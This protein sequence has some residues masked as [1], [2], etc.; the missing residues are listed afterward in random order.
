MKP[1]YEE[2]GITIYH[3]DCGDIL[4]SLPE[5]DLVLTSPPY[6]KGEK[7]NG[8]DFG[9]IKYA[10][11]KDNKPH[12]EYKEWQIGIMKNCMAVLKDNGSFLYNHKNVM[13]NNRIITPYEWIIEG[14]LL[15]SLKQEIIWNRKS[16]VQND[17][18]YYYIPITEKIF[19]FVGDKYKFN[20]ES[21]SSEIITVSPENRT[22]H[23][24]PYPL[25]LC[26]FLVGTHSMVGD[27]VLDPFM[28][29][30]TTLVAA[31]QLGRKAIGIEIEEK[32]CEIAVQR[33][34]QGVLE[35]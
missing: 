12:I 22:P 31:K 32:Y 19:W 4:P 30:G 8:N 5:V 1:Y 26:L 7:G 28:G 29:S 2:N 23:P 24:A 9:D 34:A 6:N 10:S 20:N 25:S 15:A 33:L 16:S 3:G 21:K 11:Y 18:R 14:G 35:F 13:A 27:T 17:V